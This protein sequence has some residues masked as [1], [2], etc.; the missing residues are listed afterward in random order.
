MTEID[1]EHPFL[2][3]SPEV[4]FQALNPADA[5]PIFERLLAWA[6]AQVAALG[7]LS[8]AEP[9][10]Y[11]RTF[12]ALEAVELALDRSMGLVR[13]LEDVATTP[14]WRAAYNAVHPE[15][16]AFLDGLPLDA[17]L[18]R[19]LQAYGETAEAASLDP[20]RA[21][22]VKKV[23]DAFRREG[24][25]LTGEP[26]TRL[27]AVN[28][29]L[30]ERTS[31]FAQNVVDATAGWSLHVTDPA[32]LAGVPESAVAG[33]AAEAEKRGLP[34]H[35]LTLQMPC[36]QAILTWANDADLRETLYRAH[37]RRATEAPHDNVPLVA[38]I[39][40]LRQEKARLLGF[41]SY[42]DLVLADRMAGHGARAQAFVRDLQV[43]TQAAFEAEAAAL[44]AFRRE[45]G[46]EGSEARP[47]APWDLAYY[48]RMLQQ[49]RYAYDEEAL[50]PY[51]P[52]ERV[53]D[54]AFELFRRLYGVTTERRTDLEVWD[55]EV[56]TYT[57]RDEAGA[58]VGI[59]HVD[60]FPRPTKRDGAWM[61]PLRVSPAGMPHLGLIA[62]NMSPP[63]GDTPSLLRFSEVET[64]FHELGH[65]L[66][67]L[68]SRVPVR[69]LS[70]A[71]VAW[72]FVELPS[73]I[74]EN[75]CYAPAVLDLIARHHQT[76]EPL[77]AAERSALRRARTFRAA[78]A[79]MRQ[80]AFAE[81]D[82]ALHIDFDPAR[83][84]DFLTYARALLQKGTPAPLPSN[85][86]MVAAFGHLFA[87][88]VGYSAGYYS[89]KWAEVLDADA[90]E[91]LAPGEQIDPAAG[92]RFLE[93]ILSKGNSAPP[94]D[95]F[96][97]FMGRE[98][99][100]LPLLRRNGLI[101]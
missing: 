23:L 65:L 95:L 55:P 42:A 88:P 21:R 100:L 87:H 18:W 57:L 2:T 62:G 58:S 70:G 20:V 98:P 15:V 10:T 63:V 4:R 17:G 13:H 35:V 8:D 12:G 79:Q 83:D 78:T 33:A 97:A 1:A 92:R 52:L 47:L 49:E 48:A 50:R 60:L 16:S 86:A 74:H 37:S 24:A 32:A 59:F 80:L 9:L 96:Q 84:G 93:T 71:S 51:F 31:K 81:L 53:L 61:N 75:F 34:G 36:Y 11:E 25:E 73:Q 66:H 67:H 77:P 45:P 6:R 91:T 89:Y 22:H 40:S 43:R 7:S 56:R 82:L 54:G 5:E 27:E 41:G 19:T 26:K 46:V 69:T 68:V 99:S 3:E 72:D 39:L 30:C 38:E 29:A 44:L 101:A 64:V 28:R 94:E 14:E 90:Y 76:G 85:H